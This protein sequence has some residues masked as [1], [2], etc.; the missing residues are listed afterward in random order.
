MK[1]YVS[2]AQF[3]P[4][5][6]DLIEEWNA[7]DFMKWRDTTSKNLAIVSTLIATVA[8][9]ATFNVPGSYG[10]DGKA[11]LAGDRMYNAFLILDT[12]SMV[13]SVVAT[14][15]LISGT[16]SRSNRSWLS[17][18][19]A[20]HFLWLSLN[21]MVIGFFAAITAVMSKKK[22]IRIAMSNLL[23]NGMY[24]LITMLTILLMPGSFRSIV[25]FLLGFRMKQQQHTKRHIKR[26]YPIIV[27]YTFNVVL[28]VVINILVEA[29]LNACRNDSY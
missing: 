3:Q 13:T 7:H 14:I 6:Q 24:V 2:E 22:G 4:Q 26:Q 11:N 10:D 1:L 8:F 29:S 20:M 16:A 15:L 25:K 23:Y 9:S 5:R 12:F 18:V 28:F 21:S 19:I 27:F 17:F